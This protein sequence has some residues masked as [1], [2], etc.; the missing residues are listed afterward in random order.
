MEHGGMMAGVAPCWA[1]VR[2]KILSKMPYSFL[3]PM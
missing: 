2:F 3:V 1:A